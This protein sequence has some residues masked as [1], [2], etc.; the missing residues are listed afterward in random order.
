VTGEHCWPRVIRRDFHCHDEFLVIARKLCTTQPHAHQSLNKLFHLISLLLEYQIAKKTCIAK[1][2]ANVLAQTLKSL[3]TPGRPVVFANVYDILSARAVAALP[4]CKALATASYAVARANGVEDDDMT[5]EINLNAARQIG[6]VAKEFG[7]PLTLDIQDAYGNRL[8]EAIKIA[9]DAGVVGVNLE[10]CD[11]DSQKMHSKS[12]AVSRIKRTL[13]TA[14]Q[15]G[16]PDFVVNARCDAL[17][18]GGELQE[19]IERGKAYLEAGATTV[20]VW[21]GSQRG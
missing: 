5:L 17:I 12:T 16:V 14:Q 18:H 20:F 7:K 3:H 11:K 9:I 10:D 19:V 21:G 8:E 4:S 15:Q 1:M 6:K 13:S 2:S